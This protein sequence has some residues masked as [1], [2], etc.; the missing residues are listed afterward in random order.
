MCEILKSTKKKFRLTQKYCSII[1]HQ[2][3]KKNTHQ[4]KS[5]KRLNKFFDIFFF[6]I[7]TLE[8]EKREV[9]KYKLEFDDNFDQNLVQIET[10]IPM[11]KLKRAN[12]KAFILHN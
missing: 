1:H 10:V 4:W 8:K 2:K 6:Q 5:K 9:N 12:L 11:R 3:E 7:Q